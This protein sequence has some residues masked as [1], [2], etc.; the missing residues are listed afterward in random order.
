[1]QRGL[2][3]VL[4]GP[5]GCGKSTQAGLLESHL[6]LHGVTPLHVREPGGTALGE[7]VRKILLD[8]GHGTLTPQTELF[9]FSACRAQLVERVLRPALAKGRV[10]LCD[11][12]ASS[13][14]AYQGVAGGLGAAMVEAATRLATGGLTPDLLLIFDV[15]PAIG[16]GRRGQRLTVFEKR[17][18]RY[19]AAVRR[20]FLGFAKRCGRRA[21]VLDARRPVAEVHREVV[22]VVDALLRRR[23]R[24]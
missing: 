13:T 4:D 17:G 18:A 12:W 6:R 2:F 14:Y 1:M 22:R 9:L 11:R 19:L 20:G 5:D 24:A 8:A 16:I 21:R 3:I 15:P 10:V 7:A 23:A